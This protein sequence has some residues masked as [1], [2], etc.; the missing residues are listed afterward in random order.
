MLQR[1]NSRRGR[2]RKIGARYPC[3]KLIRP[4]LKQA[5]TPE[6]IIRRVEGLQTGGVDIDKPPP[7]LSGTGLEGPEQPEYFRLSESKLGVLYAAGAI[8]AEQ[9]RDGNARAEHLFPKSCLNR[10]V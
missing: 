4:Q 2:P 1:V 8:D 7:S 10:E 5:P 3:G 6:L 9:F